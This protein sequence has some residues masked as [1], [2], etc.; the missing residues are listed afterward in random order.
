MTR[1]MEIGAAALGAAL[2]AGAIALQSS[3]AGKTPALSANTVGT[4]QVVD[5]SLLARDFA[6]GQLPSGADGARG[7][8]GATGATGAR[9]ATGPAGP[10]G[11]QG[12]QGL[13]GPAGAAGAKG[14]KG[15]AGVAAFAYVVPPEVSLQA[16][17]V[18]VTAQSRNFASV[19]NP[20]LGLYCLEP[21]AGVQLLPSERSWVASVEYSRSSLGGVTTAE[22]DSAGCPAGMFGV[23]TL[24]FAPS[25]T[26][27]W[28]PAW[29]V[30]FM[31]LVP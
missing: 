7:A 28:E 5:G 3:S 21:S 13:Q 19:T 10:A 12:E 2:L 14:P 22:P 31:V 16:D 9:G 17:P 27:H 30:A 6:P 25:P 1:R 23:R 15:D 20:R 29:D 11:P 24:R 26:P 8:Q 18:L 4:N